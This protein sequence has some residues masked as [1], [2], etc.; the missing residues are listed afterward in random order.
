MTNSIITAGLVIITIT[1]FI[2]SGRRQDKGIGI[3]DIAF[4]AAFWNLFDT[5]WWFLFDWAQ[6]SEPDMLG[7]AYMISSVPFAII[8]LAYIKRRGI[9]IGPSFHTRFLTM[10][11]PPAEPAKYK[12]LLIFTAAAVLIVIP[13]AYAMEFIEWTPDLRYARMPIRLLEYILFVGFIE[14][15]VFRGVIQNL[16]LNTFRFRHGRIAAFL[17][18]NLLFAFMWTHAGVP[19]PINWDYIIM[20]FIVGLFYA[21]VYIKSGNLWTGAFLHGLVDFLWI[22]FF[23]G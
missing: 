18:A 12:I 9:D 7:T 14:E 2:L 10:P 17:L 20:A 11:K 21:G 5:G 1:G 23:A 19:A 3:W 8:F 22:T 13:I 6:Q 4:I 16:L 15:L